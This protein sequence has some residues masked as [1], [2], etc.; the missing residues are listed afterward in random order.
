MLLFLIAL[1]YPFG[2]NKNLQ[3][4]INSIAGSEI[5]NERKSVLDQIATYVAT[6][7]APKL[8]FIC[9]HN[10]RR[11]H[12]S[13]IW[14]QTMA[15]KFGIAAETFSGGTE[16][17][18]FNPN[19]V[20]ALERAG[21]EIEKEG[22]NNPRYIVRHSSNKTPM[23]A[24]SKKYEEEPNP[25][26]GFAAV[27]TCSEADDGCPVVFGSDVRIKLFYEDPKIADG[28]PEESAKYDER[29]KQIAA[30]M[31]YVFNKISS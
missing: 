12:L 15:D 17:T 24:F 10:S 18:A 25:S 6:T 8:N 14:A 13:Q 23:I 1:S 3:H 28:T 5:T 19:A 29:C 9:T 22:D 20:A 4:Y 2:M 30:E 11:S 7:P 21:F 16:A 27:M 26:K 31:Y